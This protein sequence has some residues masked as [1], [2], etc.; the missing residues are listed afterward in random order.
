MSKAATKTNSAKRLKISRETKDA[1]ER[2]DRSLDYADPDAPVLPPEMWDNAT[3]GKYFRP[4]KTAVTFRADSDV[5]AW[6]KSKGQ[7][8]LTRIN[9]ILRRQ[10]T[11]ELRRQE[12]SMSNRQQTLREAKR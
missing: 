12:L 6:L 10:M 9:E 2:R 7:G 4:K 11:A 5:L 3:I 8:H 1:Y